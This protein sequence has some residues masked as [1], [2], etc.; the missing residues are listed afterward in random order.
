MG[1]LEMEDGE[2]VQ[3]ETFESPAS[4]YPKADDFLQTPADAYLW[5]AAVQVVDT[6]L[7][8]NMITSISLAL[9]ILLWQ[10]VAQWFWVP[11][12]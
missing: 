12:L 8:L 1:K 3:M 5:H 10:L 11:S 6:V 7:L 2:P 9:I 4:D